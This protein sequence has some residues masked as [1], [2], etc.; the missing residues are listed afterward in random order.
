M[1]LGDLLSQAHRDD[2]TDSPWRDELRLFNAVS[3]PLARMPAPSSVSAPGARSSALPQ[4]RITAV[5][6]TCDEQERIGD[7]IRALAQDADEVIVIDSGSSDQTLDIVRNQAVPTQVVHAPWRDDFASQRNLAFDHIHDG[8]ILMVD[9]DEILDDSSAGTIRRSLALL[10][11]LLPGTELA[12]CPQIQDTHDAGGLYTDLP[13][14]LRAQTALRYRGRIH[15][16]PYDPHGNAPHTVHS[17]SRFH[18]DGYR[19]EVIEAKHKLE[20]HARI[21]ELCRAQE[22]ENPKW[23]FYQVRAELRG[24]T[25]PARSRDLFDH[26]AAS[27]TLCPQGSPDYIAERRQD[28]WALLCELAL[29]F[30]GADEITTYTALLHEARREAEATYFRTVV[31]MSRI[32]RV[33]TQLADDVAAAAQHTSRSGARDIGRLHELHGLLSLASGRY[34]NVP[35]A[36]RAALEHGAGSTLTD[37]TTALQQALA[38]LG[39]PRVPPPENEGPHRCTCAALEQPRE[40]C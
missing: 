27:L 7:C 8:W 32:L 15:E 31:T 19:P 40:S 22:P 36:L 17:T 23:I 20:R 12:V 14:A 35:T 1:L 29:R 3:R 9:A 18:H 6:L 10:D 28:T 16:R 2:D 11:L 38:T 13:R 4:P 33:L 25:S 30:A 39:N 21:L 34:E 26:L 24:P 37:E 5:I